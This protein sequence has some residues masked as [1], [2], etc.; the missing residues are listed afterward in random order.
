VSLYVLALTD[1]PLGKWTP[2][3]RV[4]NTVEADGIFAIC[5]RRRAAP[6]PTDTFLREQH[7]RVVEIAAHVPALLPARFGAFMTKPDLVVLLWS[8][9]AEIRHALDLVRG[10]VQMTLRITG[11]RRRSSPF[12]PPGTG[13]EYL[14]QRRRARVPPLPRTVRTLLTSLR[15]LVASERIEAAEG[16]LLATVYHLVEAAQV[17]RYQ[18]AI[19]RHALKAGS[20]PTRVLVSGPGPAF[21]FTSHLS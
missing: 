16:P 2:P 13:R 15:P 18:R 21:A 17:A 9:A 8:R 11:P 14:E 4:L 19:G 1:R 12:V 20:T 3:G 6:A 5:E 10:R 7:A